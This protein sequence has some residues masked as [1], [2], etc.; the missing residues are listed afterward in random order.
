MQ[1][2]SIYVYMYLY[3]CMYVCIC[4]LVSII[5]QIINRVGK[6]IA[7]TRRAMQVAQLMARAIC[8]IRFG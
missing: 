8:T 6:G 2:M 3:V 1:Y 7:A 5:H 4:M